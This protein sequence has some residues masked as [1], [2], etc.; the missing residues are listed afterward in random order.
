[1]FIYNL[2]FL[3][4]SLFLSPFIIKKI[5]V[6]QQQ[7]KQPPTIITPHNSDCI[8]YL[9]IDCLSVCLKK[10]R[11]KEKKRKIII[12]IALNI[13]FII[14]YLVLYAFYIFIVVILFR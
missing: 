9:L 1:M 6:L 13:Y 8:S 3:F 7:L 12:F 14:I 5:C 11:K 10:K 2:F 4:H